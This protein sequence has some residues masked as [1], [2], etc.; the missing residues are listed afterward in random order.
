MLLLFA[1]SALAGG[2]EL[3]LAAATGGSSSFER[4][5]AVG[6][7]AGQP[8]L[9]RWGL[10]VRLARY[11]APSGMRVQREVATEIDDWPRPTPES[12]VA[13]VYANL[14]EL[15]ASANVVWTP[16]RGQMSVADEA[17]VD[18]DVRFLGGIAMV[19]EG[20]YERVDD[21]TLLGAANAVHVGPT[22]GSGV[23]VWLGRHAA[24]DVD[25]RHLVW[26]D[27][28]PDYQPDVPQETDGQRRACHQTT[29]SI[30]VTVATGRRPEPLPEAL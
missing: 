11:G 16:I 7:G 17:A 23:R 14:M 1:V 28:I 22:L 5:P 20:T 13:P 19:S 6:F 18:L 27:A 2:P 8:V 21:T 24:L 25:G 10:D 29:L 3:T 9:P 4:Q 15:S 30:G 26:S 12:W